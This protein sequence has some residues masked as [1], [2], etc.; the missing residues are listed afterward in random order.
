MLTNQSEGARNSTNQSLPPECN[1]HARYPSEGIK[2]TAPSF[3]RI[4]F[5]DTVPDTTSIWE[6]IL[7]STLKTRLLRLE[8]RSQVPFLQA[9]TQGYS[10][11]APPS[12]KQ[13]QRSS[14]HSTHD[15]HY[16]SNDHHHRRQGLLLQRPPPPTTRTT[17]PTTTTTTSATTTATCF[18]S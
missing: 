14:Q 13:Q 15:D 8:S 10:T 17:T 16:Y 9:A 18:Y 12:G 11:V 2:G 6:R 5:C 7:E 3:L 4:S 1:A